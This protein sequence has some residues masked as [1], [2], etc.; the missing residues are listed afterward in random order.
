[1][2]DTVEQTVSYQDQEGTIVSVPRHLDRISGEGELVYAL[3]QQHKLVDRGLYGLLAEGMARVEPGFNARPPIQEVGKLNIES[4]AS[5]GPQIVFANAAFHKTDK[6]R[7]R[8]AGLKVF[9]I[10]GETIPESF[11]TVRL[12]GRVLDCSDKAEAYLADLQRLLSLVEERTKDIPR[13]KRPKVMF[14][15]PKSVYT[16]ATGEMLQTEILDRAGGE[17]VARSL[18]GFW[19]DVSPEQVAVWNPDVILLGSS[20]GTYGANLVYD[21]DQFRTVTAVR[22][23]RVH[24]FPSNI[25]W[26]D[27]PAPTCVLGVVW[28]AKTLYPE[29]FSDVDVLKIADAYYTKY[30]GYSFTALGGKLP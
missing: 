11:E 21:N 16:V 29:R 28:A 10:K 25:E 18:K 1:V 14:A 5:L 27:Y 15:G 7:I 6:E 12:M 9:A 20:K 24:A 3:G 2:S 30:R 13:D 26:W 22:Q 8:I 19:A 17:N 4:L 23:H